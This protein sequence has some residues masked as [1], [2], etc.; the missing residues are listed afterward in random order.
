MWL[1]NRVRKSLEQ[2]QATLI[3]CS[4]IHVQG[5][6]MQLYQLSFPNK[7]SYI[8][9]SSK[10]AQDRF[11]EHCK[12]NRTFVSKAIKK[13]GKENVI[14]TV[15][16]NVDNWELLC[17][18]EIEAIEKFNTRKPNGYNLTNGG[19][20]VIGL[21]ITQ[22]HREKLSKA[23]IGKKKPN[24][25]SERLSIANQGKKH[26]KETIEKIKIVK[27]NPSIETRLKISKGQKERFD[28][29]EEREKARLRTWSFITNKKLSNGTASIFDFTKE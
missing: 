26:S 8:G 1:G 4:I 18:A 15:L 16:A 14:V 24:G 25:F 11:K 3:F 17:L 20:G 27:S 28:K 10:N 13:Y 7:K 21:V 22:E 6:I 23:L 5:F 19:D 29:I 12:E 9:I 2:G